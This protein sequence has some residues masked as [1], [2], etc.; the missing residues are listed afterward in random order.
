MFTVYIRMNMIFIILS[1]QVCWCNKMCFPLLNIDKHI[2][3]RQTFLLK[4]ESTIIKITTMVLKIQRY[5]DCKQKSHFNTQ[6]SA[7][8]SNAIL[9]FLSI[10]LQVNKWN[11]HFLRRLLDVFFLSIQAFLYKYIRKNFF[12]IKNKLY[13]WNQLKLGFLVAQNSQIA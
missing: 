3:K 1:N 7:I 9:D 10:I 5:K 2:R 11:Q 13:F 6:G 12:T 8:K 4:R